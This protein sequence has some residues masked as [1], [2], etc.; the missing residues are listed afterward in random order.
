LK[1][2]LP[3]NIGVLKLFGDLGVAT[4]VGLAGISLLILK[5]VWNQSKGEI[6]RRDDI[7]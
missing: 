7:Y 5:K 1:L 6:F 2:S 3:I 4:T